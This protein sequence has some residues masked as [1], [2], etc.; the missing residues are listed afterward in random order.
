MTTLIEYGCPFF[1][2]KAAKRLFKLNKRKLNDKNGFEYLLV[3]SR[4]FNV[5]NNGYVGSIF[6]YEGYDGKKYMG[7]YALRKHHKEVID[8]ISMVSDMFDE[9]YAHTTHLNAVIALKKAGFKWYDKDNKLLR[10]INF[11]L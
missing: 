3:N 6:V 4:F 8:A 5:H 1:D 9:V 2:K 10:R 11:N 7:G